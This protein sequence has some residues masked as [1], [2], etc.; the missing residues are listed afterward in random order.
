MYRRGVGRTNLDDVRAAAGVEPQEFELAVHS[1]AAL[2]QAVV[3][4]HGEAGLERQARQLE[5]V[6]SYR[7]LYN[8]R[9]EIVARTEFGGP[10]GCELGWL[11]SVL[12]EAD[13]ETW[14]V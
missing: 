7:H 14:A 8:W 11:A 2:V 5:Q 12:A 6:R 10:Y 13:E 4:A 9:D 1:K 3:T